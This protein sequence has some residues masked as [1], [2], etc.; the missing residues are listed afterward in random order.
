MSPTQSSQAEQ[1]VA[2]YYDNNTQR[3]LTFGQGGTEG[4]IHRAVWGPGV[5]SSA[6]AFNYVNQR[7]LQNLDVLLPRER[8]PRT[9]VVDLGCGVGAS[10][11]YLSERR[12]I[13]GLGITLSSVQA[14]LA[15][16]AFSQRQQTA[17]L[18]CVCGSF[19]QVPVADESADCAYAIEAFLHAAD[20]RAFFSE[21]ARLLAPG[22]VLILCDDFLSARAAAKP[23]SLSRRERRWLDEFRRGWRVHS[24]LSS[25]SAAA[26]ATDFELVSD[27]NLTPYLELGRPRDVLIRWCVRLGRRLPLRSPWWGNL[28]GGNGLQQCL[29]NDVVEYRFLVLRRR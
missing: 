18:R 10:L 14:E 27:D 26:L 15:Q 6:A 3:F 17:H 25:A 1:V 7:L 8:W 2:A 29:Q 22:G 13:D 12:A 21:A 4:A 20:A 28:L 19:M 9:R 11:G 16:Q 24:L 5:T 23:E